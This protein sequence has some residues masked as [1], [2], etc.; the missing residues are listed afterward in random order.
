MCVYLVCSFLSEGKIQW[1][2]RRDADKVGRV[3]W[4]SWY[5]WWKPTYSKIN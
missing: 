4:I 3:L 2:R 1:E 5:G